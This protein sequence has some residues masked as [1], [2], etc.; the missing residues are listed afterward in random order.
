MRGKAIY[1]VFVL[2]IGVPAVAIAQPLAEP[3]SNPDLGAEILNAPPLPGT[4]TNY[5]NSTAVYLPTESVAYCAN[6]G[7]GCTECVSFPGDEQVVTC[8][9]LDSNRRV[10]IS[11]QIAPW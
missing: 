1:W 6:S 4:C 5:N 7:P 2:A 9:V 3:G 10:C 8:Y 11:N